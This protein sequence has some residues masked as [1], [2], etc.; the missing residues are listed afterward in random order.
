MPAYYDV[1]PELAARAPDLRQPWL[2]A[3]A[4]EDLTAYLASLRDEAGAAAESGA[5]T[6]K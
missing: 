1:S 5:D 6:Q 3:S 2:D 4:V